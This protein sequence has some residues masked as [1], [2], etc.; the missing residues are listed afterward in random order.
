MES[1]YIFEMYSLIVFVM[2][3]FCNVILTKGVISFL[4]ESALIISTHKKAKKYT[5][6]L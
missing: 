4:W 1:E 6:Q 3:Y 2:S 5:F